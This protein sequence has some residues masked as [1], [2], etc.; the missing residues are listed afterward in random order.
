MHDEAQRCAAEAL[1][2]LKPGGFLTNP[3]YRRVPKEPSKNNP[4][5]TNAEDWHTE[6]I[7]PRE[8]AVLS[9]AEKLGTIVPDIVIH[10]G[11]PLLVQAVFDFKFA[12]KEGSRNPWGR[13]PAGHPYQKRAQNDIYKEFL[14]VPPEP[15]GPRR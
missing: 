14:K 4:D 15:I 8:E 9:W 1:T 13:Y 5:P 12:C 3:R 6:W 2:K 7:D 10:A 11:Y